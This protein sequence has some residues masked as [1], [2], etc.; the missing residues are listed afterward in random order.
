MGTWGAVGN[1]SA[2]TAFPEEGRTC[3]LDEGAAEGTANKTH[4]GHTRRTDDKAKSE[5]ATRGSRDASIAAPRLL[6]PPD[7]DADGRMRPARHDSTAQHVLWDHR[8]FRGVRQRAERWTHRKLVTGLHGKYVDEALLGRRWHASDARSYAEVAK[9]VY[10]CR[11][12]EG[13]RKREEDP[14][15]RMA[16]DTRRVHIASLAR[17]RD[18]VGVHGALEAWTNAAARTEQAKGQPGKACRA[19]AMGCAGCAARAVVDR[20]RYAARAMGGGNGRGAAA[21]RV[22]HAAQAPSV[23]NVRAE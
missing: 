2:Q 7:L 5:T 21:T 12:L 16:E 8:L 13:G 19:L 6:V 22:S 18:A 1:P 4:A 11:K 15:G 3:G 10:T 14:V 9:A 20:L 17:K 23:G